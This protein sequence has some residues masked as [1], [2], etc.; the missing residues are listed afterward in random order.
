MF[1]NHSNKIFW[2]DCRVES[3]R[4][5]RP[6]TDLGTQ[7]R[8]LKRSWLSF[9]RYCWNYLLQIERDII[10]PQRCYIRLFSFYDI[11]LFI[12][13]IFLIA[14]VIPTT[15]FSDCMSHYFEI[16]WNNF[17]LVSMIN[18]IKCFATTVKHARS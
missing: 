6:F 4:N 12:L 9:F 3:R 7:K 17:S 13:S 5:Y 8:C 11:T 18:G 15:T 1:A 2:A 16:V 10:R 14:L